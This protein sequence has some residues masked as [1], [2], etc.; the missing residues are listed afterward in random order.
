MLM[1]RMQSMK[2][3]VPTFPGITPEAL[4]PFDDARLAL[5]P[6]WLLQERTLL[7]PCARNALYYGV[8]VLKLRPGDEIL[9]PAFTCN[10]VSNPLKQAG[11]APVYF[12]VR[13]DLSIDWNSVEAALRRPNRIKAFLWYHFLGLSCGFDE[14]IPFCRRRGLLLIEDCAHALFSR[15]RNRPVGKLGDIAVFSISK[16]IPAPRAGALV[17]NNPRLRLPRLPLEPARGARV[18]ALRD[19]ELF[20]HRVHLQTHDFRRRISRPPHMPIL[21][22]EVRLYRDM[23]D[24]H[25]VDETSRLV[26]HNAEPARVSRI[27]NRN[28]RCYLRHLKDIAL[29]KQITPGASP[30]GFPVVVPDRDG[31]RKRLKEQGVDALCHWPDYLLPQGVARRFPAALQLANSILSLPCHHDLGVEQIEYVCRA[32]RKALRRKGSATCNQ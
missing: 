8:G 28:F 26:M 27:R 21:L 16:T 15:Y 19:K 20:L 13:T 7:L 10:T 3:Y 23:A 6:R 2:Q 12:N 25:E 30:I 18:S 29:F 5:P 32:A 1:A 14:V 22:R 4:Q 24:V 17:V 11:A 31:F 9:V